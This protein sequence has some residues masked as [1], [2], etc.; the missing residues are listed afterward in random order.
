MLRFTRILATRLQRFAAPSR[1]VVAACPGR[2]DA[3]SRLDV[4]LTALA[5]SAEALRL[6]E[7]AEE[8]LRLAVTLVG[9]QG[10][11]VVDRVLLACEGDLATDAHTHR[12]LLTFALAVGDEETRE[13]A[14]R[15]LAPTC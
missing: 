5:P 9:Q 7:L 3:W 2:G 12:F 4:A 10:L 14:R 8:N 13:A 1:R 6:R 11:T 15:A